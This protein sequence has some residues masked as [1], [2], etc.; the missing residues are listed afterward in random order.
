MYCSIGTEIPGSGWTFEPKYDGVRVLAFVIDGEATLIT[1]NGKNK[2]EQFPEIVEALQS[3]AARKK[4]DFVI[5][6]EI[7]ALIDGKPGRF[8]ELQSRI[9]VKESPLIERYRSAMPV[10]LMVFDML[11]AGTDVL[12]REPW[13][14]RRA[15]LVKEF[16]KTGSDHVRITESLEDDGKRM[17]AL[18]RKQ[19]WEGIIAKRVDSTYEPGVRTRAWLKLKIEF[20]QEF[21]VGSLLSRK[22]RKPMSARIG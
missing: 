20:T 8:Q 9:H 10:A 7:V 5:D 11:I 4:K 19:G 22:R 18:A 12:L 16:S 17:L 21:V 3:I 1:R 2:T 14:K 15:R 6:G 13:S